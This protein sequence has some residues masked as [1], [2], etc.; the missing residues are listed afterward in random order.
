MEAEAATVWLSGWAG[1]AM[2]VDAAA[3]QMSWAGADI[4]L[5][6]PSA[7]GARCMSRTVKILA[8]Q[9]HYWPLTCAARAGW[10]GV[11]ECQRRKQGHFEWISPRQ[12]PT[13]N[14]AG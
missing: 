3:H 7:N 1:E 8:N 14:R 9:T 2:A 10:H 13:P 4:Q 5:L 6:S 12:L 11:G